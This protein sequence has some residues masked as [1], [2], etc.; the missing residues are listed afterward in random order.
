MAT[1]AQF[2]LAKE[3]WLA[4]AKT[5]RAEKE[6]SKRRYEE[7]KEIELI[8]YSLPRARRGRHSLAVE[9]QNGGI[10]AKAYFF[11]NLKS[12]ATGTSPGKLFLDS[13]ERL[14]LEGLQEPINHLR[15]FLGLGRLKLYVTDQ[16]VIWDRV[17]DI[18]T[19]RGSRLGDPQCDTDLILL[20]KLWDLLEIP[21]GYRWNVRPDYPLGS[22]PPLDYRPVMM[23]NWTLSP[24]KEFPGPQIY[25]LTFG[26]NDAV[27]ID[28]RVPF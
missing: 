17:V 22:P 14:G 1:E 5:A 10:S 9:C 12:P 13:V 6:Y 7:D 25:L 15:N 11:P 21:E 20:R 16:L 4:A 18:W 3:Q 2:N 27:V 19:L 8:A 23:A 26:K 24:T 28:A